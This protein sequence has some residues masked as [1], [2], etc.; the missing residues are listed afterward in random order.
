MEKW[1]TLDRIIDSEHLQIIHMPESAGDNGKKRKVCTTDVNRPG[2]PLLGFFDHFDVNRIQI[3]GNVEMSFLDE[4]T[5]EERIEIFDNLFSRQIPAIV[6]TRNL[7]IPTELVDSA[8]RYDI[9]VLASNR[10]TSRFMSSLINFLNLQLAPCITR[11]GVL[12]SVYGEGIL[13]LG[14]SGVGKSETA[15]ELLKRGHRLIADDA[16]ELRA[17]S[18][19]TIVG[20]APELIRY[21]IELRGIGLVDV[22]HIFGMGAVMDTSRIDFVVQLEHWNEG[23][24]YDR[25]GLETFEYEILGHKIPSVTIPVSP[26]RNLA[27][28]IEVAA[29]NNRQKRSGYNAAEEFNRRLMKHMNESNAEENL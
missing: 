13:I 15:M 20:S 1:V 27:I 22:R 16:V 17:V 24:H 9:P 19:L 23:K 12:V 26:G 2:L 5:S 4:K 25:L 11:H 14:E 6:I 18:D 7:P 3:L 10:P 29:A 28:I 21:M 8:K